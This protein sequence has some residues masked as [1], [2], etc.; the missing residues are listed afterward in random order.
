MYKNFASS[1]ANLQRPWTLIT[2]CF[3]H[4]DTSHIFVNLFSFY[5]LAPAAMSI[6]TTSQFLGLYLLAGLVGNG[7][8]LAAT[9]VQNRGIPSFSVGASGAINGVLTFFACAFP[10]QKLV[11]MLVVPLPAWVAVSG[12]IT[13]DM[14]I[15]LKHPV[16]EFTRYGQTD[17]TSIIRRMEGS[18]LQ[19]I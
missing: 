3:S 13:Y 2:S 5:F 1:W 8:Q 19:H 6:L 14:Y 10:Y 12:I 18:E 9:L 15:A 4:M 7:V 11:I 17:L 16:S